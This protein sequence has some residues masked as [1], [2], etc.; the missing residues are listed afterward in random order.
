[1]SETPDPGEQPTHPP[2]GPPPTQQPYGQQPPAPG[3]W[4]PAPPAQYTQQQYTPPYAQPYQPGY[5]PAYPP[6]PAGY[7][8]TPPP[9]AGVPED[10]GANAAMIIGIISLASILLLCGV[11]LIASPVALFMGLSAKRRI[12][13]SNGALRGRGN[14]QAGFVM[15]IIGTVLL[16]L[17]IIGAIIFVVVM[18][19][20]FN[21]P[22]VLDGTNA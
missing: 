19:A 21:D 22:T 15:G 11:G 14:A 12:D 18:I 4:P 16:V 20:A 17:A 10:G 2:A 6:Q 13:A 1:M 3:A 9:G 5:P 8:V 7:Y